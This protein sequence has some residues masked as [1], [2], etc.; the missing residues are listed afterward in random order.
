MNELMVGLIVWIVSVII[1]EIIIM[2][3]EADNFWMFILANLGNLAIGFVIG[4]FAT[5][6]AQL[7]NA[8]GGKYVLIGLGVFVSLVAIKIGLFALNKL[9]HKRSR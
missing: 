7:I 8:V 5:I 2:C 1:G 9:I 3:D 6:F 4:A